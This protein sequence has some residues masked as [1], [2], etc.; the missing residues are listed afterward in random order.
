MQYELQKWII[1]TDNVIAHII[2]YLNWFCL[3]GRFVL[4]T[5]DL[6]NSACCLGA[7]SISFTITLLWMH[8]YMYDIIKLF[9]HLPLFRHILERDSS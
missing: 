5:S 1:V 4:H 7:N 2:V 6:Y 9:L 8:C 3:W